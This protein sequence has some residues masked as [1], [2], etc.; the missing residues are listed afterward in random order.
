MILD[1]WS[2][3]RNTISNLFSKFSFTNFLILF[4]GI[5]IGILLSILVYV[6]FAVLGAKKTEKKVRKYAIS[7][8]TEIENDEVNIIIRAA[9]DQFIDEKI[10]LTFGQKIDLF[11]DIIFSL[12]SDI[13]KVYNPTSK[14]PLFEISVDE[15]I[16]LIKYIDHLFDEVFNSKYI[17]RKIRRVK[18]S[19]MVNFYDKT[20]KVQENKI[21][22]TAEKMHIN[23]ISKTIGNVLNVVNPVHWVKKAAKEIMI[24]SILNNIVNIVIDIVGSEVAKVYSKSIFN[25]DS[26]LN[27]DLNNISE[28]E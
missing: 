21:V 27:D 6:L 8:N 10:D 3:I 1:F 2:N 26:A 28:K 11:R 15:F 22:K 20:Q 24:E 23:K 16:T 19:S 13:A 14:Y 12:T 4:A 9:K 18:I 5:I 25:D 7:R 17:L